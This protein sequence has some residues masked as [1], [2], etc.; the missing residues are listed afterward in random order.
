MLYFPEGKPGLFEMSRDRDIGVALYTHKILIQSKTEH[1]LPKW[2]RF[3]KGV[4]DSEDIP[5]NLSRE[6]LQN[7]ALITKLRN[8]LTNRVL[9]FLHD[10]SVKETAEFEKFYKDYGIFLKEGIITS[11][12]YNTKEEIAKLLRFDSNLSVNNQSVS[13]PEYCS[14]LKE[15]Q[16]DVYYLAA[17]NRTLAENSPYY[18][19]LKKKNFEVLFCYEPYD[20]LVLMQLQSFLGHKLISVEKEMRMDKS[21]ESLTDLSVD[22]L[23]QS[24]INHLIDFVKKSLQSKIAKVKITNKLDSHPCVITVEDMAAARHF[25]RTQSHNLD[26]ENRFALLQPHFEINPKNSIIKKVCT[27]SKTNEELANLIT[28]QLFANAMVNAGLADDPRELLTGMNDLLSKL[29]EKY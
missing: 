11:D 19:D 17:P 15:G 5:L 3:V 14:R 8:V 10:K 28:K 1:M 25:I 27:L 4:V 7:S 23:T 9:R 24:D 26:E 18:E 13:L 12:N 16:N 21:S 2:L 20:E 29:L 22:S 6:L